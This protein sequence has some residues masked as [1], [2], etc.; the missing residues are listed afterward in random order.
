MDSVLSKVKGLRR[1]RMPF[2]FRFV[3]DSF[4]DGPFAMLD[5]GCGNHSASSTK[6]FFPDCEYHGIDVSKDY[7]NDENDFKCM[8]RFYEVDLTKL[9]FKG[10]PDEFF[11]VILMKHILEHLHNGDRV[12]RGLLSKLKSGGYLYLEWPSSRSTTFPSRKGCLNFFDDPSHCRQFNMVEIR[13][14]L[15]QES[16]EILDSGTRH[17]P[18]AVMMTPIMVTQDRIMNGYVS[19]G[20][21]WDLLGFAEFVNA[22]KKEKGLVP[23][24]ESPN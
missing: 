10:I 20:V 6:R 13:S 9:D 23:V 24:L 1:L 22:R 2:S 19:G 11:D 8:S 15:Q 16:L 18:V 5:V 21:L 12:L 17:D 4:G 3:D 14:I 7:C